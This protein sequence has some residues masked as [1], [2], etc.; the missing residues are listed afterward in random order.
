MKIKQLPLP[1]FKSHSDPLLPSLK[2]SSVVKPARSANNFIVILRL[3]LLRSLL[4]SSERIRLLTSW[5]IL[6]FEEVRVQ[7]IVLFLSLL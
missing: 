5:N 7:V 3:L 2:V 1:Y 4:S 6:L